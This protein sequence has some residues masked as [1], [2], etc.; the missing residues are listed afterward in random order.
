MKGIGWVL[1]SALMIYTFNIAHAQDYVPES[2]LVTLFADGKA[3]I[4]YRLSTDVT[5]PSITV[6]LFGSDFEQ[7]IVVDENNMLVDNRVENGSLII[8]T[9]GASDIFI[10]YTTSDLVSKTGRL[11]T[12]VLDSTIDTSVR[13]PSD[14][15]IIGLNQIPNSIRTSDSQY[16]LIMPSGHTEISY[17]IGALGTKEHANAAISG[18]ERAIAEYKSKGIVV[19][20]AESKL[21]EAKR[22]FDNGKYADAEVLANDAKSIADNANHNASLASDTLR[23]ADAAIKESSAM[24][25]DISGAQQLFRQAEQEYVNGSYDKALSLAQE[26]RV[27][28][29]DARKIGT[30]DLTYVIAGI[31]AASAVGAA[32]GA[33]YLRNRKRIMVER[34]PAGIPSELVV[35]E[36]RII[37]INKIFSEKPYLRDDD[38]EALNYIAEKG[39][40]ALW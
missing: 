21:A 4:E 17:V 15:V 18:A 11:W 3:L 27:L 34:T 28:A 24:G 38:K 9:F 19:T 6:P 40:E 23:E 20:G 31:I 30:S 1:I 13:L 8:D 25:L 29:L 10:T 35:K 2:M 36:K 5:V 32:V 26:A 16:V 7:L 14:S 39:G 22:A 33:F 37:D 12:F